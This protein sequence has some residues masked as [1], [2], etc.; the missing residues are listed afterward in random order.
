MKIEFSFDPKAVEQLG[1]TLDDVYDTIKKHFAEKGLPC[2]SDQEVLAFG[3]NGG[4]NDF[5]YMWVII[6]KLTRSDWFMD[7]ATSC[8][9]FESNNKR[10]DVLKQAR[11]KRQ[12]KVEV[13]V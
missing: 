11:E 1:H 4:K 12:T 10:E 9:W 3:G 8:V 5:A 7:T 13:P 2:L 6:M